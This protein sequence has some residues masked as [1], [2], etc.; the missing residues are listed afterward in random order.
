MIEVI[1]PQDCD[2]A[3]KRRLIKDLNI[4]FAKADIPALLNFF[5]ES[6][7]WEMV[8]DKTIS[9]IENVTAFLQTMQHYKAK[10]LVLEYVLSHGKLASTSGIM[11]YG[12]KQIRFADF[13]EFTS[14]GSNKIKR[15]V[16]YAL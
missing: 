11:E 16:S 2:N 1:A 13:Y 6:I 3:P 4:A 14:A 5:H 9:G 7:E 15:M 12:D 10:K 8:N